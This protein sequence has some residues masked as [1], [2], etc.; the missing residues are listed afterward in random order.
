MEQRTLPVRGIETSKGMLFFSN[1]ELGKKGLKNYFQQLTDNY[2]SVHSE[3]GPIRQYNIEKLPPELHPYIDTGCRKNTDN[4]KYEFIFDDT[5]FHKVGSGIPNR[6]LE[7]EASMKPNSTDFLL[8]AEHCG[9]R[10]SKENDNVWRLLYL[11]EH[12]YSRDTI[13]APFQ[14]V[15]VFQEL[16]KEINACINFTGDTDTSGKPVKNMFDLI[17]EVRQKAIGIIRDKYDIRGHRSFERTMKD[18]TYDP[19]VGDIRLSFPVRQAAWEGKCIYLPKIKTGNTNLHYIYASKEQN[20]LFISD[21]PF[22]GKIY[23]EENGKIVPYQSANEIIQKKATERKV[24]K[25]NKPKL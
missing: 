11:Y 22:N 2:F 17:D 25:S 16:G 8:L 1:S 7:F 13:Q 5:A 10:M 4:G 19:L 15:P 18:P 14:Y 24:R 12:G 20:K 23:R 21:T 9:S 6:T 3:P